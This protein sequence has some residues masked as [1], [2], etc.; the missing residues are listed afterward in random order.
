M[1]ANT[2]VDAMA[3]PATYTPRNEISAGRMVAASIEIA[4]TVLS[5]LGPSST[6]A[7][8]IK[9]DQKRMSKSDTMERRA[10]C[11]GVTVSTRRAMA[12]RG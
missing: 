10:R 11:H 8:M 2:P 3:T 12:K 1:T 7:M 5:A 6:T 4:T 9:N